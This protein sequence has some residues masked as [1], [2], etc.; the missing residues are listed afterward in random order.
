MTLVGKA[1]AMNPSEE[2]VDTSRSGWGAL[3]SYDQV[4]Q[5]LANLTAG[6]NALAFTA[7]YDRHS[8]AVYTLAIHMLGQD[9]ADE[10]VQ[11]VFVRL[12]RKSE[13]YNPVRGAFRTWLLSVARHHFLDL[14]RRRSLE[15]R[16]QVGNEI[17]TLLSLSVAPSLPVK[18]LTWHELRAAALRNALQEI[19]A[20]QRRVIVLAYFGGLSQTA[21]ATALG[22]PLGTVKKRVRLGMQKLRRQLEVLGLFD[23]QAAEARVWGS[24][25]DE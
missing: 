1:V 17:D 6:G 5:E 20:E 24:Q 23:D 15:R 4:D 14:L 19:P 18:E 22:W 13:R 25:A 10:A 3:T 9:A 12:W 11:E 21:I 7:L 16:W 2:P 8:G